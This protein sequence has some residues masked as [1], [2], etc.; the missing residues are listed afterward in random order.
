MKPKKYREGLKSYCESGKYTFSDFM[1]RLR[2]REAEWDIKVSGFI[3]ENRDKQ[4]FYDPNHPR[5][6]VIDYICM[7]LCE[8]LGI[9]YEPKLCVSLDAI[10]MPSIMN[11]S[12]KGLRMRKKGLELFHNFTLKKYIFCYLC[13]RSQ[14]NEFNCKRRFGYRLLLELSLLLPRL[15]RLLRKIIRFSKRLLKRLFRKNV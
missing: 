11:Y 6:Q 12:S 8:V 10:E 15:M 9:R 5:E 1:E 2:T 7:R 4:L 13:I 3:E 14:S